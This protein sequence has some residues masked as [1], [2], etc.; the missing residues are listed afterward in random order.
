[1]PWRCLKGAVKGRHYEW[2]VENLVYPYKPSTYQATAK[3]IDDGH[4]HAP[5][6]H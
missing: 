5:G 3:P 2:Y 4:G 1:M 6:G